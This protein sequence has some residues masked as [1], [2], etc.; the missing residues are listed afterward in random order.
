[1]P[2]I[3]RRRPVLGT[4]ANVPTVHMKLYLKFKWLG[5]NQRI[6]D[7]NPDLHLA[8]W[9]DRINVSETLY[10]MRRKRAIL[11]DCQRIAAQTLE[12]LN[13]KINAEPILSIRPRD[14]VV[15]GQILTVHPSGKVT[16]PGKDAELL[17]LQ[18]HDIDAR[19]KTSAELT[20]FLTDVFYYDHQDNKN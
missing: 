8:G 12:E 10:F 1:M 9:Y 19:T 16:A 5:L 17:D 11:Q 18:E 3:K 14:V 4:P 15:Y 7:R 6:A 20:D 13:Q 2:K